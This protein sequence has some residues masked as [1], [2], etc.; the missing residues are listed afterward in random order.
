MIVK[1]LPGRAGPKAHPGKDAAA[2]NKSCGGPASNEV[3]EYLRAGAGR[4][5][6]RSEC[7]AALAVPQGPHR[8]L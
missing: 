1:S 8:P 4:Q 3:A 5:D 7:R 2:C 6:S